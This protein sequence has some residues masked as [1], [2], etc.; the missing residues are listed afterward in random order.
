VAED[1]VLAT[2]FGHHAM[3]LLVDQRWN[4]MVVMQNGELS[5]VDILHAANKQRRVPI[6]HPLIEVARSVKTCFG[7]R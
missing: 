1:R 2:Q 5:D 4:R 7:D 6:D 3:T